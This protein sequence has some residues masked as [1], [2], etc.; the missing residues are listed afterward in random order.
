MRDPAAAPMT[1]S[2]SAPVTAARQVTHMAKKPDPRKKPTP[3]QDEFDDLEPMEAE[4][5]E[6]EEL[7]ELVSEDDDALEAEPVEGV[8]SQVNLGGGTAARPKSP[9]GE[10]SE[11]W[12][13]L[14]KDPSTGGTD[15]SAKFDS[16]SDASVVQGASKQ[17][18]KPESNP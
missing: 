3:P 1:V 18:K 17:P 12:A 7:A 15:P 11:L 2:I 6:E 14:V 10:S 16:P 5:V 8:E 9:S 13:D 4:A